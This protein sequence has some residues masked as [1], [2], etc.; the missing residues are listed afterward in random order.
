MAWMLLAP[1]ACGAGLRQLKLGIIA[2]S[3]EADSPAILRGARL[4]VADANEAPGAAVALEVRSEAGQ[5]GT[6]G[7]DAVVL[8]GE[9]HVD[10][11]IA[12]SDGAANHLVLQVSG[13]MRV[14]V[15]SLS[16]DSSVMETGVPWAVCVVPRADLEIEALFRARKLDPR[17]PDWWAIVPPEHPGRAVRHDLA[18]AVRS[19]QVRLGRTVEAD[20]PSSDVTSMVRLVVAAAPGGVLVWL[21]PSQ[22]GALVAA[23]RRAGYGGTLAGPCSIDSP[24][25][26]AAAGAAATGVLAAEFELGSGTLGRANRFEERFILKYGMMPDFSAEAAYDAVRVL[27]ENLSQAGEDVGYRQFPPA[28]PTEGITGDIHFDPSGNRT[29]ALRILACKRG[30]FVPVTTEE[31]DLQ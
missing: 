20:A 17:S 27:V 29:G 15:A 30:R 11:I 10:A 4:A 19:T 26:V 31:Y 16:S 6:A 24:D 21:P 12:P 1:L 2:P 23:L 8:V 13:R 28:H 25:F 9:K 3:D 5:W 18:K 22:A 14:P 7:N